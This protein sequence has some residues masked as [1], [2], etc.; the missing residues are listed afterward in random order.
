MS[1]LCSG[2]EVPNS[3]SGS[4]VKMRASAE[5]EGKKRLL[6]GGPSWGCCRLVALVG[7]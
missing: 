2:T 1:G 7:G 6:A 3:A 5:L 4:A